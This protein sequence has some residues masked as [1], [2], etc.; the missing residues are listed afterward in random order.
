[1]SPDITDG[2]L[3]KHCAVRVLYSCEYQQEPQGSL[4][5]PHNVI[6][7]REKQ[8]RECGIQA[9]TMERALEHVG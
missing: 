8:L 7:R 3:G 9:M 5:C 2:S 1:M 6:L 4:S